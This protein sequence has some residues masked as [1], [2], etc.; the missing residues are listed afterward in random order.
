[1]F[2]AAEARVTCPG[3]TGRQ[4]YKD[5]FVCCLFNDAVSSSDCTT[6]MME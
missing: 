1:V 5:L 4:Y 2:R 3:I 6:Q